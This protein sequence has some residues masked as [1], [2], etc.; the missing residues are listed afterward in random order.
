MIDNNLLEKEIKNV[1]IDR[2]TSMKEICG[3]LKINYAKLRRKL[4]NEGEWSFE[5]LWKLTQFT[6]HDIEFFLQR[7]K[8]SERY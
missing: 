3:E 4:N 6:G 2:K 7:R 5:D 8:Q 1:C